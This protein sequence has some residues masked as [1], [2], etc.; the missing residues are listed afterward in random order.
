MS[1]L[2]DIIFLLLIF[3]MLT[4]NLVEVNALKLT[5]PGSS[6]EEKASSSLNVS[7]KKNGTFYLG[8]RRVRESSLKTRLRAAVRDA[9]SGNEKVT[10]AINAERG[11]A[12]ENVVK[13]MDVA[14][15]LKVGAVL[16]TEQL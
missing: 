13:V 10:I 14:N 12:I 5:L 9:K 3:F 7:I 11:A 16:T 8:T 15:A 1:S 6:S 2:T 4:S